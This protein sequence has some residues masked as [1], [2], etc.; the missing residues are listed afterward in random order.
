MKSFFKTLLAG[1][2][3][4][5][6]ALLLCGFLLFALIGSIAALSEETVPVVSSST[7]LRIDSSMPI[8]EQSTDDPFAGLSSLNFEQN[9]RTT[10]ILQVVRAIENATTD[11]AVKF[12]YLQ[13][14]GVNMGMANLEEVRN[15]LAKFRASGKAIIAYGENFSQA[16]Y[17]LASVADKIY[18]NTEG[19][20]MFTGLGMNMMFFK[21]ILDKLGVQVQLI[22]HGKFKAAAEQLIASN[23]SP[24]NMEQ[25][26]QML[27]SIWNTWVTEICSSR[28][29]D[30]AKFNSLI[31]N[32]Q[33]G[34]APSILENK[35]VDGVMSRSEMT[36][37]LCTLFGVEKEKDLK[38]ISLQDYAKATVKQ[39]FKAKDKIAIV[40]ANGEITMD[41]SNTLSAKKFYPILSKIRQDES[42][43]GVVLR[44]NSP[45]GDAQA[46]EIINNELQLL[47]KE[48]PVVV[49]MGDYA[50]S[51]GYWIAA[52]SDRIFTNNTTLT[53]SIGVFSLYMNV[54]QGLK[55][56]LDINNVSLKTN[57]HAGMLNGIT[58]LDEAEINYMQ[59]FVEK[60]YTQF[61]D[62]VAS[63][64]NL[65]LPYVD[66][67]GQGRVW[68]GADAISLKLADERGGLNDAI[69]YAATLAG[70]EQYRTLEYP[71]VK[72][73][74]EKLMEAFSNAES[75]AQILA[76]PYALI[77]KTY[78]GLKE[79]KGIKTYARIPY[80]YEFAH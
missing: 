11:P 58:S 3:G 67:V 51:G 65:P 69:R 47:R 53:G 45:G 19:S 16:D 43:K 55:K 44:V 1:F 57:K 63:G 26:Q 31:D 23:I 6:V 7:I 79:E 49:S 71:T 80:L 77:E 61:T 73:S 76:N 10:G 33:L 50:A 28:E 24:E 12:I 59:G 54:G 37:Q 38:A 8:T 60:I 9:T 5:L 70:L 68:T 32:L 36:G 56:H 64:R 74:V 40:Y 72:S 27:G 42:I 14:K 62:L 75:S 78:A 29:I 20:A 52:Q 13:A 18:L 48:K 46:A 22:R 39:N 66:S 35:L 34:M 30:P 15:A 41:G 21:D 4:T 17:Y 2:L 25:N